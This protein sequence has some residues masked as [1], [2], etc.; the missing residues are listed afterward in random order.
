MFRFASRLALSV[1]LSATLALAAQAQLVDATHTVT[2][3]VSGNGVSGS[4]VFSLV[5]GQ[6]NIVL[7]D[8]G[9]VGDNGHVLTA[10]F[11]D[12]AGNPTF[13]NN[14]LGFSPGSA[15]VNG[16]STDTPDQHWA[17]KAGI[18][19]VN[20]FG[21]N[22][23]FSTAGLNVFGPGDAF[24]SGATDPANPVIDGADFGLVGAFTP[25]NGLGKPLIQDGVVVDLSEAS[26]ATSFTISNVNF[27]FG[28][29]FGETTIPTP[30][31]AL[32]M[33]AGGGLAWLRLLRP[34]FSR[35]G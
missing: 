25:S 16:T 34:R 31:A 24:K 10:L 35:K 7:T 11:F 29:A 23:G 32:V 22:Y 9:T 8:T 21:A 33:M 30:P 6:L 13:S 19:G 26:A 5:G 28:T 27:Q 15:Y 17:Y 14:S 12:V 20:P 1:T 18:S 3:T 2:K 4:A